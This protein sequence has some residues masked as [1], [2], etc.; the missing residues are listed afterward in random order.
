MA[1]KRG[2]RLGPGGWATGM[3]VLAVALTLPGAAMADTA[4]VI[5]PSDPHNPTANSGWQAGTCK[6]DTPICSVDTPGQFFEQ[7]AGHPQI[8]FTQFIVAHT[9]VGPL[10]TP[11]TELKTVRVELPIGLSV[12]PGATPRCPLATF[13]ANAADCETL[14]EGSA[15]V[16]E[17]GVTA[18]LLG[19]PTPP[20]PPLT[21][22]PVYNIVPEQ[23]EPARFGLNLVG[24]N[25]YLEADVAWAGDYHEGFTIKVPQVADLEPLIKGLILKN[26]LSFDGRSGDGTFITT[27]STCLGQAFIESGSLYSTLLAADSYPAA[28]PVFPAGS[29]PYLESPIPP[30]TSPKE[31]GTIPYD[32][33]VAV[34]PGTA[35]TNS[36]AGATVTVAVPH[37]TPDFGAGA[38][39]QDSSN[40]RTSK[41]TLPPGM[42]INPSAAS[43][44]QTCTDAE[45]GK[46]T[47]NPIACPPASRVGTATIKSPPLPEGD[48]EG[49]VYV[50]K[51]LSRD[52]L[53]GE[54]YRVFIA[55]ESDRYGI[56]VRLVGRVAAD[57]V[58]GQLT[59][60]IAET[61]QVP[62]TDFALKFDGGP[63][64]V[65]SSPPTCG[66]NRTSATMTPWAPI[67]DATP[68]GDF[69][70]AASP[71]GGGCAK[72]MAERPF[73]PAFAVAPRANRAGA[74]S[75]LALHLDRPDGQQ[76]LKGVDITLPAGMT[77]KL[78]GIPY[79]PQGALDAAAANAGEAEKA[80]SSCPPKSLVGSATIDA[81]TGPAPLQIGGKVFLS[82][83]YHGA[84]L[85]LAVVTPAT[86]GPFDL[87]TVV[88]RV[89]LFVD[90][91]TAQIHAVSDPIPDVYGGTQLSVR[92]VDVDLDRDRF[93]L[94]PTSCE[95]L[96]GGGAL[97][98]GGANPADAATFSAYPVA[99]GFQTSD[100]GA[101]KFRPKLY[102]RLFGKRKSTKRNRYPKF[103]ATLVAR[104]GDANIRRAALT[105]SHAL[106]L[107]QGHIR[108]ICTRPRLAAGNCPKRSIYG[109]AMARS[110]LLDDAAQG[111]RLPGSGQHRQW[112]AGPARRSPRPGQHPPARRHQLQQGAAEDRLPDGPRRAGEQVRADHEGRQARPARQHPRPLQAP[113]RLLPQLQGPE[114]QAAEEEEA[115]AAGTRLRGE[116]QGQEVPGRGLNSSSVGTANR[117]MSRRGKISGGL[118]AAFAVV[119]AALA[120]SVSVASADFGINKWEAGTC[121]TNVPEC[122]YASPTDQ[123]FTQAAG[124]PKAGLTDF[125]VNTAPILGGPEGSLKDVRVDLPEGLNVDPQA[126]PQCPKADFEANPASCAASEVGTSYVT[127]VSAALP[128]QLPFPVYNLVPDP[129]T[130]ALVRFQRRLPPDRRRRCLPRRRRRLGR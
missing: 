99:I 124:H 5:A 1:L 60:T 115:E 104:D 6:S 51:Q 36:P 25:V 112:P 26:R 94:N 73:A 71:G 56:S 79:C 11:T 13:E 7:A 43:G 123:F 12:N 128:L 109:H 54:E 30:G 64:S 53:S 52:P 75:P 110:P 122:T 63:R 117:R 14:P 95:P 40:T 88:V 119:I 58:T 44:L 37:L 3:V 2:K 107:E 23:G 45:F 81:G 8:G 97:R 77:G 33:T 31:C 70:L 20:T 125:E 76:E 34:D 21:L 17:S 118:G 121:T 69:A 100:C 18:S 22:V 106:I 84:P 103:R 4:T 68:S 66:P 101:L 87:G 38:D 27:P 57:P 90:P 74:F 130:P 19:I 102:T 86:A 92:T 67:P 35:A 83:P 46:G 48:L 114:R 113:G 127:A 28:D 41:V 55:A 24:N 111:S 39:E 126:V 49:G 10:E 129:G 91:E 47:K 65:L 15:K 72:T 9:T 80:A 105:L 61:P 29:L 120:L 42:G 50:G 116:G 98:G 96:A 93:T 108:T 59:T 32:P 85:S 82:G 78:A 16:G 62:F 89:A